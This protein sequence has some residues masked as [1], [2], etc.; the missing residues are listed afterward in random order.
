VLTDELIL[1]KITY[2]ILIEKIKNDGGLG[3]TQWWIVKA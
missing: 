3:L 1:F 2:N